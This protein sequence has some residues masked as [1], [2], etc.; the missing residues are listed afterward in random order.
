M[1]CT[2]KQAAAAVAA[3]FIAVDSA[4]ACSTL[5]IG[6]KVSATGKIIVAH[7]EDNG[8]RLFNMHA[9]CQAQKRRND[10]L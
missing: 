4:Q 3:A 6:K 2:F 9:A 5:V 8:G 1:H 10:S 7:N